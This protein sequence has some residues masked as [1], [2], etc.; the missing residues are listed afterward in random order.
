MEPHSL[1]RIFAYRLYTLNLLWFWL[2]GKKAHSPDPKILQ[3]L[4][5][6]SKFFRHLTPEEQY[7]FYLR[8]RYIVNS[9]HFYPRQELQLKVTDLYL[10]CA[11]YVKLTFGRKFL[12]PRFFDRILVY[13][14][15]Y[16]SRITRQWH[17]GEVSRKGLIVFSLADLQEGW[18]N[19]N[20]NLNLG[21]HEFSHV[22]A[23]ELEHYSWLE[24]PLKRHY[25]IWRSW[26]LHPSNAKTIK[27]DDYFRRYAFENEFEMFAVITENFFET[28]L[29]FRVRHPR[30]YAIM[31]EL[32]KLDPEAIYRRPENRSLHTP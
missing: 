28:P 20:D 30:L 23:L 22:L 25:S 5:R 1:A 26:M 24:H 27:N 18:E 12:I 10:I 31:K 11:A 15:P 21:M 4:L 2:S 8:C 16:F 13:P 14:T 3:E 6:Y 9:M 7:R 29:E 19:H 32:Y 17:K